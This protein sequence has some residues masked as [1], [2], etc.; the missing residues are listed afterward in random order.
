MCGCG[1]QLGFG[2]VKIGCRHVL[3]GT[4]L[5]ELKGAFISHYPV[6]GFVHAVFCQGFVS[7][8]VAHFYPRPSR[9]V[10]AMAP[11]LTP[12]E[13]DTVVI[14]LGKK[15]EA[16]AICDIILDGACQ[17]RHCGAENLGGSAS[18]GW[19]YPQA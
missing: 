17:G 1:G 11:H 16:Q 2:R 4:H 5:H 19:R 14:C 12:M 8:F 7:K 10:L 15:M 13:L 6:S 9:C 18:H 3:I